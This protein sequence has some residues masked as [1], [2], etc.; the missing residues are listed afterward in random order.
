[1][2]QHFDSLA[3]QKRKHNYTNKKGQKNIRSWTAHSKKF[4]NQFLEFVWNHDSLE[5]SVWYWKLFEL[6][7]FYKRFFRRRLRLTSFLCL[8][9]PVKRWQVKTN[10]QNSK[11]DQCEKEFNFIPL[12]WGFCLSCVSL[13]FLPARRSAQLWN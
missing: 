13:P 1:M 11:R 9:P 7:S 8:S 12:K 10:K 6:P 5:L 4:L 3:V 2:W